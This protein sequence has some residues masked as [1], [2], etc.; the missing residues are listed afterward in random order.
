MR[1]LTL[2]LLLVGWQLPG[3]FAT[4][5]GLTWTSSAPHHLA[6]P[7]ADSQ[8]G[9]GGR[10]LGQ[11]T[12]LQRTSAQ[13]LHGIERHRTRQCGSFVGPIVAQKCDQNVLGHCPL[14]KKKHPSP[15][16]LCF[17]HSCQAFL[18]TFPF[19]GCR[20]GELQGFRRNTK[21]RNWWIALTYDIIMNSAGYE[22]EIRLQVSRVSRISLLHE[23]WV[24]WKLCGSSWPPFGSRERPTLCT[25]IRCKYN[26]WHQTQM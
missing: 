5:R 19:A 11:T 2:L 17:S 3:S 4:R 12:R 20:I 23:A 1:C 22:L 13:G 16:G 25:K 15:F 6:L 24:W 18:D 7:S 9:S 21:S 26:V 14:R 10:V 8:R